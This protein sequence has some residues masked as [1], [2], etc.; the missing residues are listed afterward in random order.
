MSLRAIRPVITVNRATSDG[1]DMDL[2]SVSALTAASIAA[3]RSAMRRILR[4]VVPAFADFSL[5][6]LRDSATI[7][8]VTGAHATAD[9]TRVVSALIRRYRIRL[10]D[11][12]S[13]VAQVIRTSKAMVRSDIQPEPGA[14]RD[15]VSE[16]HRRLAPR[17]ALVVPI[18]IAGDVVGALTVCYS[19]SGRSYASGDIPAMTRVASR[20][21]AVLSKARA[22]DATLGLRPSAGDARQGTTVR[23]RVAARD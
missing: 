12:T 23:R 6:F 16:I 8:C 13:T 15:L 5:V 11:P 17:S 3:A 9:G 14:A 22:A 18:D 4:G 7:R 20:I 19:H 2:R 10:D 21:A 1:E